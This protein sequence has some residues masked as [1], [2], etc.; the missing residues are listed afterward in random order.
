MAAADAELARTLATLPTT[1]R[2]AATLTLSQEGVRAEV[3]HRWRPSL[4]SAAY[5]SRDWSGTPQW[6]LN[7]RWTW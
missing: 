6:G 7:T 5:W 4:T 3:A 1:G 2:G